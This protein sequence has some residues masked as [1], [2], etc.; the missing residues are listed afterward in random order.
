[1]FGEGIG[2][3]EYDDIAHDWRQTL[4]SGRRLLMTP[5]S[6]IM[7]LHV[8]GRLALLAAT[9]HSAQGFGLA[10]L[11]MCASPRLVATVSLADMP[12]VCQSG[13]GPTIGEFAADAFGAAYCARSSLLLNGRHADE[14]TRVRPGDTVELRDRGPEERT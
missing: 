5:P 13:D 6:V 8:G 3:F 10:R 11:H 14:S 1:M 9:L 4:R 7:E 2:A 12:C